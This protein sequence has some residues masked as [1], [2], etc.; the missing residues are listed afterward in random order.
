MNAKELIKLAAEFG[1]SCIERKETLSVIGEKEIL[2]FYKE[3]LN[4]EEKQQWRQ[5][6]MDY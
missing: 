1:L 3:N 2:V 4:Q 5:R 6:K